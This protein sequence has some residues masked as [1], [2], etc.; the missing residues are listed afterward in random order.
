MCICVMVYMGQMPLNIHFK[1]YIYFY[2]SLHSK[3]NK[4]YCGCPVYIICKVFTF[5]FLRVSTMLWYRTNHSLVNE[6]VNSQYAILFSHFWHVLV[7]IIYLKR[8]LY[9]YNTK[10]DTNLRLHTTDQAL[11]YSYHWRWWLP[12]TATRKWF[13]I[14]LHS[15]SLCSSYASDKVK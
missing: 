11:K 3:I 14:V 12:P 9:M 13:T 1:T 7:H 15:I 5:S 8:E 10:Y 2:N 4:S 6:N